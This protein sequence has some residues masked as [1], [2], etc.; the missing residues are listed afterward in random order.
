VGKKRVRP[1]KYVR[2]GKVAPEEVLPHVV[3]FED[4][5]RLKESGAKKGSAAFKEAVTHKFRG[6]PIK[7]TS[8]RYRCFATSGL[9]CV[10]CGLKGTFFAIERHANGDTRG[11]HLNLYGIDESGAEVMLTKD[12][13]KPKSKGGG[14]RLD[15]FQTMCIVCNSK[16]A[17]K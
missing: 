6:I 17:D 10:Q 7:M 2:A 9:D 12:H 14:D 5:M 15:N 8:N 3:F 13:I 1:A 16:K 4:E 11:Y